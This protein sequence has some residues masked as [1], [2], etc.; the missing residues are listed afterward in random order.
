MKLWDRFTNRRSVYSAALPD[1]M[2]IY[3]I[4]DIH[5]MADLLNRMHAVIADHAG[6][7]D[8]AD[9]YIVYLGDYM[10]RGLQVKEVLDILAA[11]PP[12]GF[13]PIYLKGNHEEMVLNFIAGAEILEDWLAVGGRS[14][15][16]SYGVTLP[17]MDSGRRHA[18]QV[19][20]DFVDALPQ[21]H[22]DFLSKLQSCFQAGDYLFV[23]AGIRPGIP[24]EKQ[25]PE[26][27]A[28]IRKP[29]L[30]NR[31]PLGVRVVHGHNITGQPEILTCRIGMDTGA[32]ATGRLS[33]VMLEKDKTAF[34]TIHA[35]D[36]P[37]AA[38]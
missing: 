13:T 16:M 36:D 29:F 4:G 17:G 2:R 5:G 14:T 35:N 9:N 37:H 11:G 12:T 32:Y 15:L 8:P 3:A 33:C 27:F 18:K 21:T 1:R 28:W 19:R 20:K 23:H 38:A 24:L 22:L 31:K 25:N 30:S 34:I 6:K 7:A 26:D 10:D